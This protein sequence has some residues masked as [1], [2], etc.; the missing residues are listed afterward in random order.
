MSDSS[1][2]HSAVSSIT[3]PCPAWRYILLFQSWSQFQSWCAIVLAATFCVQVLMSF[4]GEPLLPIGGVLCG[5]ALGSLFSVVMV[6]PAQF[7]VSPISQKSL[8]FLMSQ[9]GEMHYV[10]GA[11]SAECSVFQQN[12]PRVFRWDEGN[13]TILN[14]DNKIVVS[15]ALAILK[16]IHRSLLN[17]DRN[18]E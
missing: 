14:R 16:K 9:L 1:P 7:S 5:I 17:I 8:H 6:V 3:Y 12:L 10:R 4:L 15:G 11:T 2:L 18:L 13:V